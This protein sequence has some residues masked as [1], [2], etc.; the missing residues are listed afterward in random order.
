MFEA[1]AWVTTASADRGSGMRGVIPRIVGFMLS[2]G[3]CEAAPQRRHDAEP[4]VPAPPV[5]LASPDIQPIAPEPASVVIDAALADRFPSLDHYPGVDA[6]LRDALERGA[7]PREVLGALAS[8]MAPYRWASVIDWDRHGFIDLHGARRGFVTRIS[9]ALVSQPSDRHDLGCAGG[10][11]EGV[12]LTLLPQ[13]AIDDLDRCE[14]DATLILDTR[15]GCD[16]PNEY[17]RR[18]LTNIAHRLRAEQLPSGPAL[19]EIDLREVAA[20][21]RLK[22]PGAMHLCT[23]SHTSNTHANTRFYHHLMI[24]L[25]T[26]SGAVDVFDTTGA[27]GLSVVRMHHE[28]F[29]R[30]CTTQLGSNREYRYSVRSA[31]LT[32]LPV[33]P[34]PS[35]ASARPAGG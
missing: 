1:M 33:T 25:G 17:G 31:G 32:C 5:T 14:S 22:A 8:T 26:S 3:A 12:R 9:G 27:R 10:F 16:T 11:L 4:R 13:V 7:G 20:L 30:Y 24:V 21:A 29:L 23:V 15:P 18:A 6:P 19:L 2:V 28:L 34:A 35:T